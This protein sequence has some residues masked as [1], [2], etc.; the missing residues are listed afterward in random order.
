MAGRGQAATVT[1]IKEPRE[2]FAFTPAA[3]SIA[4]Q[5]VNYNFRELTVAENDQCRELAT[6]S[7]DGTYDGRKH[8]R[9]MICLGSTDPKIDPEQLEQFPQRLY[10]RILEMVAGLNDENSVD[11]DEGND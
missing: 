9:L 6:D 5:G 11:D 1:P 10:G 8:M 7:K 2:P 3:K 4:Y